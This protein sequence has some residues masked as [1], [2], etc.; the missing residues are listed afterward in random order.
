MFRNLSMT[1][2]F[3]LCMLSAFFVW[4]SF[5][6]SLEKNLAPWFAPLA[7]VALI[8]FLLALEN[9]TAKQA[10]WLGYLYGFAQLGSILYWI[11]VLEEAK[12]LGPLGWAAL[13][14][15]LSVYYAIFAYVF[16]KTASLGWSPVWVAPVVWLGCE[17]F[18][19]SQP[20]GGFNW[21]EIGYSQAPYPNLAYWACLA[22]EYGLTFLILMVNAYWSDY[23][24][25]HW[26]SFRM[27]FPQWL[28]LALPILGLAIL[29]LIGQAMILSH[30][31]HRTGRVALLQASVDQDD[32]WTKSFE[33]ET[34]RRYEKLILNSAKAQPDLIVW[35]ETGAPSFLKLDPALLTRVSRMVAKGGEPE[36]IGCLDVTKK[37]PNGLDY[38]NAAIIFDSRG[39]SGM[40]Y[41]KSHLVPFGE[42]MPF[43]K[44]ISFLG[45]IVSNLG[46]FTAGDHYLLASARSFTYSPTICY[47]AIFP[48]DMRHAA[49]TGA[50][51]LV[52]ISN[53]AWYGHT[54]AAY[55]HAQMGIMRSAE[56]H[57]PML[58]AAN[59][60]IS[61]ITDPYARVLAFS[62]F[63]TQQALVGEVMTLDHPRTLYFVL[64]NWLP[65]I[66]LWTTILMIVFLFV[67]KKPE[68]IA[69][70]TTEIPGSIPSNPQDGVS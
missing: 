30:A 6:N 51:A 50:D 57:R 5:P 53:D 37:I 68:D 62:G 31:P 10:A 65:E 70:N 56:L 7:W 52:N 63:F 11:A 25:K 48:G 41:H 33:N 22:G 42:F 27:S 54:A 29:S 14:G 34:Y 43:Q 9:T 21:G 49:Q 20:W 35:P 23:L 47:E 55:Q 67:R 15:Y 4:L 61:Y 17:Y 32:K 19:G 60:G 28:R 24:V 45:P 1:R 46:N 69:R 26:K 12:Y 3:W 58:R 2:R 16:R 8:P 59:T 64:G 40:T 39:Q 44:Y 13:V 36:L 18:R 38:F 66:C